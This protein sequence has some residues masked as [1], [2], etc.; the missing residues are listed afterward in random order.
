MNT[1]KCWV[2]YSYLKE[3]RYKVKN[4]KRRPPACMGREGA[5]ATPTEGHRQPGLCSDKWALCEARGQQTAASSMSQNYQN[6]S[7]GPWDLFQISHGST[8]D[9]PTVPN[10]TAH[11]KL[12]IPEAADI[13]HQR[14]LSYC[15]NP[16]YCKVSTVLLPDLLWIPKPS[17]AQVPSINGT[18]FAQNLHSPSIYFKSSLDNIQYLIQW[19]C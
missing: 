8:K 6:S 1:Q 9:G 5:A 17:D 10:Y 7:Y 12:A 11:Q 2:K 15:C 14:K 4:K 3:Q 19:K 13:K 18:V 16:R